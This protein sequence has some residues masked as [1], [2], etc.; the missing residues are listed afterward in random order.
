MNL[1][2]ISS[3]LS[4]YLYCDRSDSSCDPL[5]GGPKPQV[6]NHCIK[7]MALIIGSLVFGI[8]I[9]LAQIKLCLRSLQNFAVTLHH[10][11]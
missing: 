5:E 4:N 7:I 9:A 6:G 1:D 2:V 8:K 11:V 10:Q 3:S